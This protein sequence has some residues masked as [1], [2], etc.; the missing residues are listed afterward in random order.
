LGEVWGGLVPDEAELHRIANRAARAKALIEDDLLKEAF[1][2]LQEEYRQVW[3][4]SPPSDSDA[5]EKIYLA[6]RMLPIVR[7]NIETLI[8]DGTI[9]R[10]QL[11]NIEEDKARAKRKG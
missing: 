4:N 10:R 11:L 7:R 2:K 6:L 8:M 3:E 5:R 1:D 9:A